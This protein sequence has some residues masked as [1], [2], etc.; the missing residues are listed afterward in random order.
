LIIPK[1]REI[2]INS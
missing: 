2:N 1:V